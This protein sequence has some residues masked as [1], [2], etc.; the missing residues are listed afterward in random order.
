M[1]KKTNA[2]LEAENKELKEKVESLTE[3]LNQMAIDLQAK[4][5]EVAEASHR[6]NV[7]G[8]C[9]FLLECASNAAESIE[10][11]TQRR[12]VKTMIRRAMDKV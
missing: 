8:D 9:M 4:S 5:E 7:D 6:A 12:R 11:E 3:E 1:A 2:Q 10:D